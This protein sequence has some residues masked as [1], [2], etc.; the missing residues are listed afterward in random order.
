MGLITN[1]ASAETV[2]G[3]TESNL[4]KAMPTAVMA[5]CWRF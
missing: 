3:A 5:N 4:E 2:D 1:L